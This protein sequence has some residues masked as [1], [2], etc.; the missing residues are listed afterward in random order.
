MTSVKLIYSFTGLF[1]IKTNYLVYN[2]DMLKKKSKSLGI[3]KC[4]LIF[5]FLFG[6]F[7]LSNSPIGAIIA[8]FLLSNKH[9]S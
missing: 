5:C 4:E 1:S 6:G 8:P 9:Y 7:D 3:L 2:K